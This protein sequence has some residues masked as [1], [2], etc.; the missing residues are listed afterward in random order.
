MDYEQVEKRMNAEIDRLSNLPDELIHKILSFVGIKRAIG[1]SDI[2][3]RWRY[4]WTSM[5]YLDF[6]VENFSM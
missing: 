1:L 2:S 6:S 5:P 4:I 3:S